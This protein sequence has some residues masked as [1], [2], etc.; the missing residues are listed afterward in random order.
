[1]PPLLIIFANA[2]GIVAAFLAGYFTRATGKR[3]VSAVVGGAAGAIAGMFA[4]M[5]GQKIGAWTYL[6]TTSG[7]APGPVYMAVAFI[8]CAVVLVGWRVQR[9]WGF[10]ALFLLLG[11]SA[12]ADVINDWIGSKLFTVQQM[13]PPFLRWFI[14][15]LVVWSIVGGGA[16]L[17]MTLVAGPAKRD[18][19]RSLGSLTAPQAA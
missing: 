17:V 2:A 7:H 12:F 14:A 10:R 13:N 3:F 16:Y 5:V 15:D 11:I 8:Y 4:D 9:A 18:P 19:L 6:N 1:M